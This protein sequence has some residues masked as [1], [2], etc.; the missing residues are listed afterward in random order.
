LDLY[1]VADVHAFVHVHA[2]PQDTFR[3]NVSIPAY[4]ALVP[5]LRIGADY[6]T[7]FYQRT[8]MDKHPVILTSLI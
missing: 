6:G 4:L 8:R 5:D 2:S 3:A 7:L 1:A